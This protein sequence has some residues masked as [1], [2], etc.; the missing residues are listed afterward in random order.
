MMFGSREKFTYVRCASCGC[1]QID[2]I[3]EDLGKYYPTDYY[4]YQ[5]PPDPPP[6]LKTILK[7]KLLSPIML[8][9]L[10]GRKSK[11]GYVLCRFLRSP[12]IPAWLY[13]LGKPIAPNSR[14]LD[15]GC[16]SGSNLLALSKSGFT[17]L[18]G[19]D[20]FIST[21]L[22]YRGGVIIEKCDLQ[23][24][25][26]RFDLIMFH[27]V[28]EHLEDPL[29]ALKAA[30]QLLAE[31]GQILIR[32]PLSDSVA[33]QKYRENWAQIDAPRHITLHSRKSMNLAAQISG[34]KI[35]K[36][37]Y[38]SSEFQFWASE[39]YML[40]IPLLDPRSRNP[41]TSNGIFS[42]DQINAFAQAALQL[43]RQEQGDQ[44]AF[45]LESVQ[46]HSPGR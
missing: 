35:T 11:I 31:G 22:S 45:V 29:G 24:V 16:G 2:K 18:R 41:G 32:I 36:V 34:L 21:Q 19:V 7:R 15:V 6:R 44:A 13:F 46:I 33:A 17:R 4:S 38:D 14:I 1:L 23:K 39:Q 5:S 37:T 30:S 40:D 12:Y 42:E 8:K 26:G 3:P 10:L 43:N 28:F 9:H 20:P 27:H 25:R